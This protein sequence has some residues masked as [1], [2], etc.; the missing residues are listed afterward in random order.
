MLGSKTGQGDVAANAF[1]SAASAGSETTGSIVADGPVTAVPAGVPDDPN[2]DLALGKRQY[3]A[4]NYGLAERHF[5]RAVEKGPGDSRRDAEAWLG[6]AA[7]YDRLRRFELADRAYAHAAKIL[8]P[9]AEVLNNQGYSYLLRGD[10]AHAREKLAA[11]QALDPTNAYV[12]NNLDLLARS[13][14]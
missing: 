2:D 8:G 12:K 4:Q 13:E 10:Y 1:S 7:S 9:S 14:R 6:L 3:R 11:A 5:R